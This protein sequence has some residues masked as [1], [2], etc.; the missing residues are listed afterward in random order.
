MDNKV[1]DVQNSSIE[2]NRDE[3]H[4]IEPGQVNVQEKYYRYNTDNKK[5][6]GIVE[7]ENSGWKEE[8]ERKKRKAPIRVRKKVERRNEYYSEEEGKCEE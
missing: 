3:M 1:C 4:M 7:K 6:K 5:R 8:I 2:D